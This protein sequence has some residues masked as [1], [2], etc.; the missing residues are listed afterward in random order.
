MKDNKFKPSPIQKIILEILVE[1]YEKK[2][3]MTEDEVIDEAL[4]RDQ[5]INFGVG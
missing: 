3:V 1:N 4:K 5:R 2:V